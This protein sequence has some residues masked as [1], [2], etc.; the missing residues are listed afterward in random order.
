MIERG[1]RLSGFHSGDVTVHDHAEIHGTVQ[2]TITVTAGRH[3]HFRGAILGNL[4]IQ[5][6]AC[7]LLHGRVPGLVL[8]DGGT[9]TLVGS[10]SL[11]TDAAGCRTLLQ[12]MPDAGDD[13]SRRALVEYLSRRDGLPATRKPRNALSQ[14]WKLKNADPPP[15]TRRRAGWK[16]W[17]ENPESGKPRKPA[18]RGD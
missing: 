18:G 17:A 15:P 9:V 6:G 8:N 13:P 12:Q 16:S 7:V 10:A 3:L 1:Q 4:I 14:D 5:K 2:G 11:V